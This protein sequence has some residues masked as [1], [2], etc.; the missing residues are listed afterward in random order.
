MHKQR[1]S[2]TLALLA[3]SVSLLCCAEVPKELNATYEQR[4]QKVKTL[5]EKGIDPYA[6]SFKRNYSLEGLTENY[7]SLAKNDTATDPIST[8]GRIK[9]INQGTLKLDLVDGKASV[10]LQVDSKASQKTLE[11]FK[12]LD[13]GDIIG[14]SGTVFRD[15]E[16]K[17]HLKPQEITLLTKALLPPFTKSETQSSNDTFDA[18]R[19]LDI[20]SNPELQ[21]RLR[22]RSLIVNDIRKWLI[23]QGYMAVETSTFQSYPGGAV[24][25]PFK[26]KYDYSDQEIYLRMAPELYIKR[27]LIAGLGDKLFELGRSFRN[28]KTTPLNNPEFTILEIFQTYANANDMMDLTEK[29]I[30]TVAKTA[31]KSTTIKMGNKTI[32]LKEPY[33]RKSFL[34]LIKEQTQVDFAALTTDA[35]AIQAA[36]N[37]GIEISPK[38]SW[39]NVVETVFKQKVQPNLIQPTFV[40]NYPWQANPHARPNSKDP[41]LTDSFDLIINGWE[42][43]SGATSLTDPIQQKALLKSYVEESVKLTGKPHPVDHGFSSDLNNGLPPSA[44]VSIGVDRLIMVLT[45]AHEIREVI[46]FPFFKQ[47]NGD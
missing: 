20:L 10:E 11:L 18:L 27:L 26:T 38:T 25:Y 24:S 9:T 2:T 1:L 46:A 15:K 36:L 40:I 44:A 28:E 29:L 41:R 35:S 17:L 7:N 45:D 12:L 47:L 42:I 8:T 16:G 43:G 13:D 3:S 19:N 5:R 4:L 39:G 30:S 31:L 21:D 23:A 37:L 33:Q 6:A 32:A 22:Q 14:V 34:D